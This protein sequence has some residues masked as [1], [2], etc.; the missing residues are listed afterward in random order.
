MNQRGMLACVLAGWMLLAC[1]CQTRI[2]WD[3]LTPDQAKG[4]VLE[5]VKGAGLADFWEFETDSDDGKL[6][7]EGKLIYNGM[8]YEFEINGDTGEFRK[9]EVERADQLR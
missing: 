7:Y 2:E 1:G 6:K 3:K 8:E 5:R 4:L 9:W